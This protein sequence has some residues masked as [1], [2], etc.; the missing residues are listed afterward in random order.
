MPVKRTG[1]EGYKTLRFR[2][3]RAVWVKLNCLKSNP[4]R[5]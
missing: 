1:G 3:T 5:S 2:K 4:D